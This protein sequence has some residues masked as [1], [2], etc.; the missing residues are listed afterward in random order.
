MPVCPLALHLRILAEQKNQW[1]RDVI[2]ESTRTSRE[3]SH[4][5]HNASMEIQAVDKT[6]NED[7]SMYSKTKQA[8]IKLQQ[9]CVKKH[10]LALRL[11]EEDE[12][13]KE[14]RRLFLGLHIDRRPEHLRQPHADISALFSGAQK[15]QSQK[16][17]KQSAE[18]R[19]NNKK[20]E[21]RFQLLKAMGVL[22]SWQNDQGSEE[23]NESL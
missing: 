22:D 3:A 11:H 16:Q 2:R 17:P 6:L 9:T 1:K 23:Q 19:A 10:K 15:S 20:I 18:S 12:K 8:R 5:S 21:D 14:R 4:V 13:E 7:N